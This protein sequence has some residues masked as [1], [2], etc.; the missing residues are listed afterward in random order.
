[1]WACDDPQWSKTCQN[2]TKTSLDSFA[3]SN[4]PESWM[5]DF[6]SVDV[7]GNDWPVLKGGSHVLS[8]TKYVEFEHHWN[9]V[10]AYTNISIAIDFLASLNF[11]C[12]W[13]GKGGKLWRITECYRDDYNKIKAWS[14]LAC[15]SLD[16]A[17][18]LA[19]RMEQQFLQ[20]LENH[21]KDPTMHFKDIDL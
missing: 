5:I 12:Y 20:T 3:T 17:P 16:R 11:V 14:N 2:V 4:V 15:A 21:S 8:R 9:G 18:E 1:M 10:W 13:A 19:D 7:E 6:L